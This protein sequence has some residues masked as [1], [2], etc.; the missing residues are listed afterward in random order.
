MPFCLS[1]F[2]IFISI[3][4]FGLRFYFLSNSITLYTG[5]VFG[6][7]AFFFWFKKLDEI[8]RLR[9][10]ILEVSK[11]LL[12][13]SLLLIIVLDLKIAS[14][15]FPEKSYLIALYISTFTGFV[16]AV[17]NRK[18]VSEDNEKNTI[19]ELHEKEN[20]GK[21][22]EELYPRLNTIPIVGY[23]SR[24]IFQNGWMYN[25]L[26]LCVGL[27]FVTLKVWM[28][29]RG[30]SYIDEYLQILS[31]INLFHTGHFG[32]L[33]PGSSYTR[34][35]IISIVVGFSQLISGNSLL[36]AKFVPAIFGVINFILLYKIAEKLVSKYY[37]LI[38]LI[39][40]TISSQVLFNHIYIRFFV[41]YEC[42]IL[43]LSLLV[44]STKHFLTRKRLITI[45]AVIA[46]SYIS[47][48]DL[49]VYFAIFPATLTL[50]LIFLL[51][52]DILG[53]RLKIKTRLV[54]SGFFLTLGSFIFNL[55]L[56][57]WMIFF[58]TAS[59]PSKFGFNYRWFFLDE[60]VFISI[61]FILGLLSLIIHFKKKSSKIGFYY[62]IS[63]CAL[64]L[65]HLLSSTDLQV[66]RS[67][68]YF[69]PLYFLFA[70]RALSHVAT[71]IARALIIIILILT[72]IGSYPENFLQSPY[73]PFEINYIDNKAFSDAKEFCKESSIVITSGRPEFMEYQGLNIDAYYFNRYKTP[74]PAAAIPDFDKLIASSTHGLEYYYKNIPVLTNL[75]DLRIFTQDKSYCFLE[76]FG[77]PNAWVDEET[78]DFL[79]PYLVKGNEDFKSTSNSFRSIIYSVN[80][81]VSEN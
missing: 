27:S 55:P 11:P 74:D 22:F 57:L 75:E 79:R 5:L 67:I 13:V 73:I 15:I 46:F 8:N 66:I 51:E 30:G 78:K 17:A 26:L 12:I 25:T 77:L 9:L 21:Q 53:I 41:F 42:V 37:V 58:D 60:N 23:I 4:V 19:N 18:K 59:T 32:S 34:G 48:V 56:K 45:M 35:A 39:L 80:D 10:F 20:K 44:L 76:G 69:L 64:F 29:Y 62:L 52:P 24:S 2:V 47:A 14:S 31:G 61:L 65:L 28:V 16:I 71:R 6:F 7:S 70:V 54:V 38:T 72:T 33:S 36:V 3:S 43:V 40:Y 63:V 50:I 68:L 81:K 49:G 1:V